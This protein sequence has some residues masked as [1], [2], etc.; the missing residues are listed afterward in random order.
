MTFQSNPNPIIIIIRMSIESHLFDINKAVFSSTNFTQKNRFGQSVVLHR[1]TPSLDSH[2]YACVSYYM[3][4]RHGE[5]LIGLL[6]AV[7][8]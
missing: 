7:N 2:W 8:P 1:P 6:Y 3:N 5:R 4:Y